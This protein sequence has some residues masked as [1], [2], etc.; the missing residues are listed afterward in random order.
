[1][2]GILFLDRMN[3]IFLRKRVIVSQHDA[4]SADRFEKIVSAR[5]APDLQEMGRPAA[6]PLTEKCFP[7]LAPPV[8]SKRRFRLNPGVTNPYIAVTAS[9]KTNKQRSRDT[10]TKKDNPERECLFY[11]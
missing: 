8:E 4:E 5:Q 6:E 10:K 1:M 7:R 3:R 2:D 11:N 9:Q